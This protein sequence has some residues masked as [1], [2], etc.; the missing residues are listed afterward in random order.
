MDIKRPAKSRIKKRARNAVLIFV[1]L[2]A[3]GGITLD[4]APAVA[5]AGASAAAI[6]AAIDTASDPTAAGLLVAAAFS[7][8]A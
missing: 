5:R 4:A 6:I 7:S 8:G 1:G 3:I 2:V